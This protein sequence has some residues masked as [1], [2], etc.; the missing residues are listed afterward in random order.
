M[1]IM[2]RTEMKT[3]KLIKIFLGWKKRNMSESTHRYYRQRLANFERRF[4]KREFGSIEAMEI[5]K[6]FHKVFQDAGYS[7]TTKAHEV[8]AFTNLHNF[9]LRE[10][11][12]EKPLFK[13]LEKPRVGRRERIPTPDEVELILANARADFR[14]LYESLMQCGARPGE[15]CKILIEEH[16]DWDEREI[17]IAQ[18]KTARKTGKPRR[19]AIGEKFEPLL[20]QAI[21]DRTAG[22]VFLTIRGQA[23]RPAHASA[24]FRR[25]RN[26]LGLDSKLVLYST[27]HRF[28]TRLTEE[29]LPTPEVA[30]LM[31]HT[32]IMT[33]QRY[34]HPELR[35]L[36]LKQDLV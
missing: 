20:R 33:T 30:A 29:G 32:S 2:K 35:K 22:P 36:R 18:H 11:H 31:G 16:I 34:I 21:G 26:K 14:L 25:L 9:A 15:L 8:T 27:R 23:W 7:D 12:I 17:V 3:A 19:I 4:G 24:E 13:K 5:D 6:H 1:N 10:E 28:G